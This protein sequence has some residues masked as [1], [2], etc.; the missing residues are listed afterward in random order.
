MCTSHVYFTCVRRLSPRKSEYQEIQDEAKQ[1][2]AELRE[3]SA[4]LSKLMQSLSR[5]LFPADYEDDEDENEIINSD[6]NSNSNSNSDEDDHGRGG[7]A[8]GHGMLSESGSDTDIG[9]NVGD[10]EFRAFMKRYKEASRAHKQAEWVSR[11]AERAAKKTG[12]EVSLPRFVKH[13]MFSTSQVGF[14]CTVICMASRM[15]AVCT[16]AVWR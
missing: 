7:S 4:H 2:V 1:L 5:P 6:A 11:T 3:Q 14:V 12:R 15:P 13:P 9:A 16:P 8:R 10:S